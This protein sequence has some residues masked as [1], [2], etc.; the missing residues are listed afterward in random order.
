MNNT[1]IIDRE[2]IS[3]NEVDLE[4]ITTNAGVKNLKNNPDRALV[5]FQLLEIFV[6]LAIQKYYKTKV[7]NT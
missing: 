5:R 3:N 4:F 1:T 6:R 7:V 2:L